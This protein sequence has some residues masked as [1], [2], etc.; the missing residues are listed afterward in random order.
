MSVWLQRQV[1]AATALRIARRRIV[2]SGVQARSCIQKKLASVLLGDTRVL[3]LY[4]FNVWQR[5]ASEACHRY[6]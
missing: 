1:A 2:R 4:Y 3:R 5:G 6:L